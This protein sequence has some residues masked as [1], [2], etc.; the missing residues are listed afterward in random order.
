MKKAILAITL[1]AAL[2]SCKKEKTA[3]FTKTDVTGTSIVRG[4]VS[5]NVITPNGSGGYQNSALIPAQ[6][7]NVSIKINKNSLYPNSSAQGADVYS[8]KTDKDGNY[9]IEVK[10]NATGVT[11]MITIDGF[12]GTLDT[13]VN[14]VTKKGLQATYVGISVNRTVY[15]GQNIQIDYTFMGS[16]VSS[17][18]NNILNIGSA[19][20]TGS[21]GINM[22]KKVMTGTMVTLT[23]TN[24]AV[25]AGHK[26]Y[27]NF[28]ND[29]HTLGTKMYETTTDGNGYYKF[30]LTTVAPGTTGF[31]QNATLWIADYETTRDTIEVNNSVK[32]GRMGV[33]QMQ[34]QNQSGVYNNSIKNANHFLYS[35]FIPN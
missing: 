26:V 11:A 2:I 35:N 21:V 23:T 22:L 12:T 31:N 28:S 19:V 16:N 1:T 25:P 10:S 30:D 32:T 20:V 29:P 6:G 13:I 18:P 17:N 4:N 34:T 3:E 8:G 5:K 9:A 24:I 33:F 7:V 14:S 27:L 15:M